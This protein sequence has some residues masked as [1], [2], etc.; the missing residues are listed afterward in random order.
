MPIPPFSARLGSGFIEE[1]MTASGS[2]YL[3]EL[4][5]RTSDLTTVVRPC[6]NKMGMDETG[7]C[8]LHRHIG[9]YRRRRSENT[10]SPAEWRAG[11]PDILETA[12]VPFRCE[13][14]A[15]AHP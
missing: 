5:D 3:V 6:P 13:Q 9:T 8:R 1:H 11:N 12:F 10:Y 15:I 7:E 14:P 4:T 2:V